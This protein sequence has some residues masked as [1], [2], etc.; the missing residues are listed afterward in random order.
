MSCSARSTSRD[1]SKV[2]VMRALPD[3]AEEAIDWTPSTWEMACSMGSTI[4]RS[5][6]GGE[7][8]CQ[9][10]ETEMFG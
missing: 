1:M 3:R 8:P 9:L 4:C 5:M 2:A 6:A 7:A 10:I